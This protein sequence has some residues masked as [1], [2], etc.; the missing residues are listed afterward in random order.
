MTIRIYIL[1]LLAAVMC[2]CTKVDK[3]DVHVQ[4]C[5]AMP[6]GR[7]SACACV[8]EGKA[9]VFAGRDQ[10]GT[11]LNDLWEYDPVTDSWKDLGESP[12]KARVNA[13]MTSYDGKIYAGLGYSALRAYNDSAYQN[14]WWEYTPQTG[15]WERLAD[16]PSQNTVKPVCVTDGS[17][18]YILYGCGYSQQSDVWEYSITS[19]QWQ[20]LPRDT[21]QHPKAFGC[22][23]TVFH[24]VT[25]LGTGFNAR[26]LTQWYRVVLPEN[27]WSACASLPGK[28][29]EFCACSSGKEHIYLFGGRYFAGDMTGGEIFDTFMRYSPDQDRW[30]W[31]GT[32]P[33][34]RA[35]NLIAFTIG[36]KPYFGL[37]ENEKG[38][39]ISQLYR[40]EE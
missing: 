11:Y 34:G 39:I 30:E 26:N 23:G 37:G 24:G 38:E 32:M 40:I 28:G 20:I 18:V 33:C 6:S 9:Y 36:E 5:A 17:A 3:R 16:Y 2:A 13:V 21:K 10:Q 14:D 12:M 31:C 4:A 22:T 1:F 35:E 25:Y 15:T 19:G 8:C 7:A 29:R 27:K